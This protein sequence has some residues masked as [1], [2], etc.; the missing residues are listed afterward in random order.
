MLK[1]FL[2]ITALAVPL[3]VVPQAH[4][5][6]ALPKIAALYAFTILCV[7]AF[8]IDAIKNKKISFPKFS[9]KF[10]IFL[11][12]YLLSL[13]IS[14]TLALQPHTAIFGSYERQQGLISFI[15]YIAIFLLTISAFGE[16]KKD[17][18]RKIFTFV[19]WIC[20]ISFFIAALGILQYFLPGLLS[21]YSTDI[22][23]GRVIVGTMG[24]PNFLAA[25][26]LI[27]LPLFFILQKYSTR[28]IIKT[29]WIIAM[30]ISLAAIFLTAT[31]SALVALFVGF[32]FYAIIKNKKLLIIPLI[33]VAT[34]M[35]INIFSQTNFIKNHEL[36]NRL[37]FSEESLRSLKSRAYIWPATIEIIKERPFFGYGME[38]FKEVFSKVSPK[39]LLTVER[40]TDSIDRAH[41]EI[42]DTT[43]AIGLFGLISYLSIL[44]YAICLGIK[45]KTETPLMKAISLASAISLTMLFINNMFSFSTTEIRLQQFILMGIIFAISAQKIITQKIS[46]KFP[47]KI[48]IAILITTLSIFG[49]Y[50]LTIKPLLADYYFDQGYTNSSDA[51]KKTALEYFKKAVSTNPDQTY[52]S[53]KSA[54]YAIISV[55]FADQNDKQ[56]FMDAAEFFLAQAIKN[57]GENQADTLS[58]KA[59]IEAF[60]KNHD[61]SMENFEKAM[62]KA[63]NNPNI[64]LDYARALKAAQKYKESLTIYEKYLNLS[65]IWKFGKPKTPSEEK[66]FRLFFKNSPQ[67]INAI[68]ETAEVANQLNDTVKHKY[69]K[70]SYEFIKTILKEITKT[71]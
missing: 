25:Y 27:T 38:N 65:D 47:A 45:N 1:K 21:N 71:V 67:L 12:L 20:L 13:I 8:F 56:Y 41:N 11:G 69:Y 33:L 43:A 51:G 66:Q 39:E 61:A 24:N 48:I 9:K 34:F 6:F 17:T 10:H 5:T 23:D 36:L 28:K 31:R 32:I 52:Y 14:T 54:K 59:N 22:L 63:P 68:K 30:A 26:L 29:F 62:Q 46:L 7:L 4:L 2:T 55:K 37:T 18:P 40:F 35:G 42:L 57:I 50:N 70:E 49:I 58:V 15:S 19:E 60:K 64:I 3:I 44:F 16:N 53:I